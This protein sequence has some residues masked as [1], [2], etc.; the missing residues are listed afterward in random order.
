MILRLLTELLKLR[1]LICL[2]AFLVGCQT[3]EKPTKTEEKI[4]IK[5]QFHEVVP[6]EL[7]GCLSIEDVKKLRKELI[8]CEEMVK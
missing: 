3:V 6:H 1:T 7:M 4:R 2:I 5:W 8:M